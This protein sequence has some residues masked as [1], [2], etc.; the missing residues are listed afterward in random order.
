MQSANVEFF[1]SVSF[2][3]ERGKT[4][5]LNVTT[6]ELGRGTSGIV[7]K[8]FLEPLVQG[9]AA[10]PCAVKTATEMPEDI[11]AEVLVY[12]NAKSFCF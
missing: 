12:R 1:C 2:I 6:Q 5:K 11:E 4:R 8:G 3:D 9:T 7:R 10:E